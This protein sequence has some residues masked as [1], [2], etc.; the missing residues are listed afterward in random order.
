VHPPKIH[1]R[2]AAGGV[3]DPPLSLHLYSSTDELQ[4]VR[5]GHDSYQLPSLDHRK[6]SAGPRAE[7]IRG[8]AD[9]RPWL[10]PSR[11]RTHRLAN[12][13][14]W[15]RS[16]AKRIEIPC[17]DH[18]D[19]RF[20]LDNHQMMNPGDSH[21]LGSGLE[22]HI[23]ADRFNLGR[24]DLLDAHH[25]PLSCVGEPRLRRERSPSGRTGRPEADLGAALALV[26]ALARAPDL[27]RVE[28]TDFG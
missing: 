10:D 26:V 23:R 20:P 12:R 5:D 14:L 1:R 17:T 27:E 19:D 8:P 25:R 28:A 3:I 22:D 15:V 4:E 6:A 21:P 24:H 18:T 13:S 11:I 16:L 7:Q 9:R 2:P